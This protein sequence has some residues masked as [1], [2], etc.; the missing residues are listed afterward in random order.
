M[1]LLIMHTEKY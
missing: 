1:R